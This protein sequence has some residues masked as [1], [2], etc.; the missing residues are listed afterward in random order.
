MHCDLQHCP[1]GQVGGS[2][3]AAADVFGEVAGAAGGNHCG[4]FAK[5]LGADARV[6]FE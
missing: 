2:Q 4:S 1:K 5:R 3:P 6:N